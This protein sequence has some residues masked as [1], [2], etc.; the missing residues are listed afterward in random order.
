MRSSRFARALL[1]ALALS[2]LAAT[3]AF[4]DDPPTTTEATT[5]TTTTTGTTTTEPTT[6][7]TTTTETTS[8][9]TEAAP[10][11]DPW[12]E[13][14]WTMA[15]RAK[16]V[17]YRAVTRR[18]WALMRRPVPRITPPAAGFQSLLEK[19]RWWKRH[20][21]RKAYW[22]RWHGHR[23]PHLA[24]WLCIHRYEGSRQ[25][26]YAPYY[27]GLQ[28]DI[29]FSAP[30]R[31]RATPAEGNRQPLDALR[32]DLGRR[33]CLPRRPRLLSL[34]QHRP[35]LRA[36]LASGSGRRAQPGKYASAF[37]YTLA[38]PRHL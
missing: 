29:A 31:P 37:N 4:G 3:A 20:W 17:H 22:A 12:A 25:D 18:W 21:A 1:L 27:G 30:V 6:T 38:T 5:T 11:P 28:M 16:A 8:T 26:P 2:V 19:R 32:A 35:L 13:T 7:E 36:Y 9:T 34:A 10:A 23:P 33:T 14:P 24:A 15:L